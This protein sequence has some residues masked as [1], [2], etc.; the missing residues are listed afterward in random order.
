MSTYL[1][2]PGSG[3]GRPHQP[4]R[5]SALGHPGAGRPGLAARATPGSSPTPAT[6]P[7]R[8]PSTRSAPRSPSPPYAIAP[9]S[10][11]P[12]PRPGCLSGPGY[13][14]DV[15][16]DDRALNTLMSRGARHTPH[17][18]A[19]SQ[20]WFRCQGSSYQAYCSGAVFLPG[21]ISSRRLS[22]AA[23]R[24]QQISACGWPLIAS[25]RTERPTFL[26]S[27]G[28]A[29]VGQGAIGR[30]ARRPD[31]RDVAVRADE[32]GD[33]RNARAWAL[34]DLQLVVE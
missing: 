18:H 4:G 32:P 23:L 24:M 7:A 28:Q 3:S 29:M 10:A 26:Q 8:A 25:G 21:I 19:D 30:R 9:H 16:E 11:R 12:R 22:E 31:V 6:P 17:W 33:C 34:I 2:L 5:D 27:A 1:R 15:H 14:E 20:H 13:N